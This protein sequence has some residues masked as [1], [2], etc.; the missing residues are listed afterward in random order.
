VKF[1]WEVFVTLFVITDPP[2]TVPIFLG[3]TSGRTRGTQQVGLAGG[4]GR[5]RR[6]RGFALFGQLIRLPRRPALPRWRVRAGCF[7]L[8]R[9]S[10]CGTAQEPTEAERRMAN[11]AFVP[12]GTPLPTGPGAIVATMLFVRRIMARRTR[13]RFPWRLSQ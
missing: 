12:L 4:R 1:F 9:C 5:I 2:G 3:L 11:V 6:D 8:V 7:V 10:C 13:S